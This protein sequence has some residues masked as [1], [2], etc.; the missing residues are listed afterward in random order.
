[1]FFLLTQALT[2]SLGMANDGQ[3]RKKTMERLSIHEMQM[4]D[5]MV[6]RGWISDS[7]LYPFVPQV[8][9]R[10]S[11]YTRQFAARALAEVARLFP[12]FKYRIDDA[13]ARDYARSIDPT[14]EDNL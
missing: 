12:K 10:V 4:L 2:R 8:A 11:A 6:G 14:R 1:M 5:A 7:E 13:L 9:E 3:E